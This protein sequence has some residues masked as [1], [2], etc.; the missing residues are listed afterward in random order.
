MFDQSDKYIWTDV[1]VLDYVNG[2]FEVK[3]LRSN[4]IKRIGRLSL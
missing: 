1:E 4:K 2:K 3:I